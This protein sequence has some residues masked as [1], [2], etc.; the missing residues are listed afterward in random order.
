MRVGAH[1]GEH[2]LQQQR[3]RLD[4]ALDADQRDRL[5]WLGIGLG[6]GVG[7]PDGLVRVLGV[8]DAI[9]EDASVP[10]EG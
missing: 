3:G 8:G 2:V 10:G 5:A 9:R 7:L 1:L 4:D 6:V